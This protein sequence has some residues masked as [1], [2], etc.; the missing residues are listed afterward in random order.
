MPLQVLRGLAV[1]HDLALSEL[2]FQISS[3]RGL[4]QSR[5]SADCVH[6]PEVACQFMTVRGI[7]WRGSGPSSRRV[8]GPLRQ[9]AK[10]TQGCRTTIAPAIGDSPTRI[11]ADLR[12]AMPKRTTFGAT[13]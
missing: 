5:R 3:H 6:G 12:G 13:G 7:G 4:R 9:S 8:A 1:W 11:A 2:L 10:E